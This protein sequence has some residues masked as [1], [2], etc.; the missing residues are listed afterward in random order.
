MSDCFYHPGRDATGAC[1]NCG[2]MVCLE[3]RTL[4]GGKMYCQPCADEV[5]V[6]TPSKAKA[7]QPAAIPSAA[8]VQKVSGAWWL[9]PVFLWWVGG[10]IAWASTKGRDPKKAKR[11]LWWGI[12]LTFL[13]GAI[14]GILVALV[15]AGILII[16]QI[17]IQQ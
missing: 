15:V 10:L 14:T 13:Y 2:K 6:K 12:G 9:L 3:C 8:P 11:M 16:P 4:L 7:E 17:I 1:V 5:F